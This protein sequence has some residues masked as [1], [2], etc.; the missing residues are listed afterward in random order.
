VALSRAKLQSVG[1]LPQKIV[2]SRVERLGVTLVLDID[3]TSLKAVSGM[4][5]K[6]C[7]GFS[8][9]TFKVLGRKSEHAAG[10]PDKPTA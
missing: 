2:N 1:W 3:E 8:Q 5:F 9:L 4:G 10:N 7:L 6:P